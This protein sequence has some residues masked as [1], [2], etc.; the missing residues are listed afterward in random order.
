MAQISVSSS[1]ALLQ[2][3]RQQ[4]A[5]WAVQYTRLYQGM[6][7]EIE[8]Q[9]GPIPIDDGLGRVVCSGDLHPL[10]AHPVYLFFVG[11]EIITRF[12][13]SLVTQATWYTDAN[14]REVLAAAVLPARPYVH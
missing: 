1:G 8:Y 10:E 5:P 3:V 9:I 2:E 6:E 14:G 4:W 11:K 7:I 13:T 12:D